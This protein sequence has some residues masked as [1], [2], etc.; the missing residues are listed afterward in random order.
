MDRL[1]YNSPFNIDNIYFH[2]QWLGN[3]AINH[4]QLF[5][6]V[7]NIILVIV[8]LAIY[9]FLKKYW[10]RTALTGFYE[11]IVAIFLFV[12]WLLFFPN[13]AYIITDVRH[14]LNY[15]PIDSPNKVCVANAWMIIFFFVYSSFGWVSFYYLLKSMSDLIKEICH[16]FWSNIFIALVIPL[17]SLGVLLGLLNRFNSLD[18]FFF[19]LQLFQAVWFYFS[20]LNYFIDW[21]IFTVFLYLL[22]FIGDVIF[23]KINR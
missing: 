6:V 14:L 20:S 18:I 1:I 22:Y 15:C 21:F 16:K 3:L 13:T 8:S 10:R 23:R 12:F 2:Y 4:Y 19:P 7:W 11:K 17:V 9:W 5:T